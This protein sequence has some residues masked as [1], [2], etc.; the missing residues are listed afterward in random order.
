MKQNGDWMGWRV[1]FF[2]G[3]V[4]GGIN[5]A[6]AIYESH[7]GMFT[8]PL[9]IFVLGVG[10]LCAGSVSLWG[11]RFWGTGREIR[12]IPPLQVEHTQRSRALSWVAIVSGTL[13]MAYVFRYLS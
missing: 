12:V 4:F 8:S 7:L 13:L 1:R 6:F 2:C 9:W 10:L 3:L 11:D 5:G